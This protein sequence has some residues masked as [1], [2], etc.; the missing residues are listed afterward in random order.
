[1][2]LEEKYDLILTRYEKGTYEK[3]K[4]S[5]RRKGEERQDLFKSLNLCPW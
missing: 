4:D 3:G 5:G 1:M 2:F